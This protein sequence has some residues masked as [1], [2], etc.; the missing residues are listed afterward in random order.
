MSDGLVIKTMSSII[1]TK[2]SNSLNKQIDINMTYYSLKKKQV[3][4]FNNLYKCYNL[5]LLEYIHKFHI[6]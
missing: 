1:I 5:R 2:I 6:N 4:I 3:C